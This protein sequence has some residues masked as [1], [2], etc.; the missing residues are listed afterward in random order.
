[1][2]LPTFHQQPIRSKKRI[3]ANDIFP[4]E[5]EQSSYRLLT[6]ALLFPGG[7][8]VYMELRDYQ[9]RAVNEVARKLTNN[10]K[11]VFQLATGGGKTITFSAITKRYIEK[12]GKAVLILVHRKELMIQTVRTLFNAYGISAQTIKAGMK[13]VPQA[14]VYVG[15]VESVNRRIDRLINVG[16]VIIDE[17]HNLSFAKMHEHFPTEFII[18]FTATPLTASK[19]KPLHKF[20]QDIVCGIDIPDL[21]TTG[22]L[23]QNITFAPKDT[24]NASKLAVK[25]GE[26]DEGLMAM[27][28]SKAKHIQNTVDA[29]TRHAKGTKC[30][31]FNCNIEHSKLVDKAFRDAG[32][33]S[34]QLDSTMSPQ[35]RDENV[36]W[37]QST[38][39]AILN[40]VAILTT[41]FDAP[42]TETVIMNRATL[43]MPLWLQCTGR[44]SRPTEAKSSF[45]IIDLGQNA[46]THGDWCM[47]RDW[48]NI[49]FNPPKAGKPGVAPVKNCPQCDA[50]LAARTLVC[51]YCGHEFA[52]PEIEEAERLSDFVVVTKGIDVVSIIEANKE[53]KEY[54]P[55]FK[56]GKDL[57]AQ[58]KNTIP[59]MTNENAEFILRTYESLAKQWC[60][61]KGKK[62]NQWHRDRAK[63]H[64]YTELQARFKKW[65][66]PDDNKFLIP[67]KNFQ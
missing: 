41:G 24:V 11:I 46:I 17:A 28:F 18:G 21:I 39:D 62:W 29:Y 48:E 38:P 67:T 36:R 66:R 26:Y 30:L 65:K 25:N 7:I 49:F 9:E 10:R 33:N 37:Y 5:G 45:T 23:C 57:A 51:K 54:Y 16:L 60:D 43:S 42:E 32:Y 40:N 34:R 50:I 63:D 6:Q 31:V 15:M 12:S 47:P 27:E 22:S 64:L 4:A 19:S 61:V 13:H 35:E 53:K 8:A 1:M 14:A 56:I 59:V 55:F 3:F 52:P 2:F 20:Y 44:G 58:A